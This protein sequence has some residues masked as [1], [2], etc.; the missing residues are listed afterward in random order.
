MKLAD[1]SHKFEEK[2]EDREELGHLLG[3]NETLR[4]VYAVSVD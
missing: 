4:F 3:L 2:P 1:I